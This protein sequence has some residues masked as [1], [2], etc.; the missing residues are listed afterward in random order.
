[1]NVGLNVTPT[2][3]RDVLIAL[4]HRLSPAENFQ[5]RVLGPIVTPGTANTAFTV[6]HNLG[7][8]PINYIWN[9]DQACII[10]DDTRSGWTDKAMSLKCSVVSATLYLIVF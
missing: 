1:M 6:N 9:I 2:T 8:V 5:C 3:L 4:D 7:R 10:Y